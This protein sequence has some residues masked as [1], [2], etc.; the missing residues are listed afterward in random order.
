MSHDSLTPILV[1]QMAKV[2][3]VSWYEAIRQALPQRPV[4]HFHY[5]S[6]AVLAFIASVRDVEGERQTIAH[7]NMF[8]RLGL[9]GPELLAML[10]EKGWKGP[11]V[12]IVAGIRE[13]MA[14]SL[15]VLQH[16]ADFLGHTRL[17]L[18]LREG[19]T[20]ENLLRIFN[21]GWRQALGQD[22][23]ED[24][25][26]RFLG[27]GFAHYRT[28]FAEELQATFGLDA[29]AGTFD[30][31]SGVMRLENGE[32]A[33][34]VYR[35]EDLPDAVRRKSVLAAASDLLGARIEDLPTLNAAEGRR[36]R[37][38]YKSFQ[39]IARLPA[40]SIA[41]IYA[42]PILH[43]FYSAEEITAFKARWTK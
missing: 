34:I 10:G 40:E 27:F 25:F 17:A 9:P 35:V 18:T 8:R 36:S 14:R 3:S 38:L 4:H 26:S 32:H 41:Q 42:A 12:R 39:A 5:A 33:A 15:S 20:A 19:G 7:R 11:P 1:F 22:A 29:M 30:R 21:H 24:S 16:G 13:P 31:S 6:P 2:A 23:A 28:W 43:K 37:D